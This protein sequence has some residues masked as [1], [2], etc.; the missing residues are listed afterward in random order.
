M[1]AIPILPENALE[2]VCDILA[3]TTTGITGTEIAKYL[4][5]CGIADGS[6][7]TK[8]YRLFEALSAKQNRDGAANSVLNFIQVV[9]DPVNHTSSPQWFE[10]KRAELNKVLAFC[11][12]TIGEDGKIRETK[13]ANTLGEAE[14]KADKLKRALQQRGVHPDVLTVCQARL[15]EENYFHAVLE[16][17]KS[18]AEKIRQR[19]SLLEDG[20]GLIDK[21]LGFRNNV[22][23]LAFSA[24]QTETEQSEQTGLMN[25]MKGIFG[26]FRNPTAHEPQTKWVITEQD[27]M[28]LL[29]MVSFLHRRIDTAHRTPRTI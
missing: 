12:L 17:C 14:Q 3:D 9:I 5:R 25:L 8:R 16:A 19:T 15:M 1:A 22:P 20:S 23:F 24:L 10:T 6:S 29:T 4:K 21:A 26:A 28:D 27:A 13:A 18:I 11:G 7:S 2:G